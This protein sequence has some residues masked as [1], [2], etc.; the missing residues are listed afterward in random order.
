MK[1]EPLFSIGMQVIEHDS[2]GFPFKDK[3]K[4]RIRTIIDDELRKSAILKDADVD[5]KYGGLD[6]V[7]LTVCRSKY[8]LFKP[9]QYK[10]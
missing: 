10:N 1:T 8:W 6:Y 9:L 3:G 5:K 7:S 4:L 2:Y